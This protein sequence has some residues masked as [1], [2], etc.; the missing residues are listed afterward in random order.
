MTTRRSAILGTL[1][2]PFAALA[3][4]FLPKWQCLHSHPLTFKAEKWVPG[5]DGKLLQKFRY[6]SYHYHFVTSRPPDSFGNDLDVAVLEK[7]GEIA[8][9]WTRFDGKWEGLP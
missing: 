3:K 1:L 4:P 8:S 2:A 9:I 5:S 7:R 6:R